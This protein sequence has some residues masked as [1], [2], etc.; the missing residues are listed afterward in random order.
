LSPSSRICFSSVYPPVSWYWNFYH[1]LSPGLLPM[2][3]TGF[4]SPFPF[5]FLSWQC[6]ISNLQEKTKARILKIRLFRI[7]R[8]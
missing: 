5:L 8:Q 4:F 2:L 3:L 6:Y 7:E 1:H